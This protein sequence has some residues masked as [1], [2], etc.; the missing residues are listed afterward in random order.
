MRE[1]LWHA[2]CS[3]N[4]VLPSSVPR[5][6]L[7][8]TEQEPGGSQSSKSTIHGNII[9]FQGMCSKWGICFPSI[10]RVKNVLSS[11]HVAITHF[12]TITFCVY[13]EKDWDTLLHPLFLK[14]ISSYICRVRIYRTEIKKI[15]TEIWPVTLIA[16]PVSC[17]SAFKNK[18][19]SVRMLKLV[20]NGIVKLF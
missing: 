14:Q 15:G 18:K 2:F 4:S 5:L 7:S 11:N 13:P 9:S 12:I 1:N 6:H 3:W 8:S 20:G 16:L 17:G 10:C 19:D